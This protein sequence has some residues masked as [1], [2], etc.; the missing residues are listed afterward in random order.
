MRMFRRVLALFL[1]MT[2]IIGI[3]LTA[4]ATDTIVTMES[5]VKAREVST[6]GDGEISIQSTQPYTGP[7]PGAEVWGATVRCSSHENLN[8][9]SVVIG[10]IATVSGLSYKQGL[11]YFSGSTLASMLLSKCT[12]NQ[13]YTRTW[14]YHQGRA[15]GYYKYDYYT[16]SDYDVY[17][18][19]SYSFVYSY[20]W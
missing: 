3:G 16:N 20:L 9:L 17:L 5:S 12:Y 4:Y 15:E 19:S 2:M 13:Y 1:S 18:G 11:A 6:V 8:T 7:I 10:F 14:Y